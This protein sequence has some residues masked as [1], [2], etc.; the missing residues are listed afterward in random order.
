MSILLKNKN[1][2]GLLYAIDANGK[3]IHAENAKAGVRYKCPVCGCDMHVST[4]QTGKRIFVRYP[5]TE[6]TNSTCITYESKLIRHT[7]DD[8]DPE[9]FI[10][11]LC[12]ASTKKGDQNITEHSNANGSTRGSPDSDEDIKT[13][14][15]TSL[16]QI[17]EEYF[18]INGYA[19]QGQHK[20]S[21]IVLSYKSD[22]EVFLGENH[23]LGA[24]I[25]RCLYFKYHPNKNALLF[26]LFSK[27]NDY[28][29]VICLFFPNERHFKEVRKKF[30]YQKE[31]ENG[32]SKYVKHE[33][34]IAYDKWRFINKK[35]CKN[36][37]GKT[38]CGNCKGMYQAIYKNPKQI[39][40]SKITR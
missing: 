31:Q 1:R 16:K 6:H 24:R 12:R 40:R 9:K 20:I 26:D 17:D 37:C 14:P 34:L 21:D 22:P 8:I 27:A 19:D 5:G 2:A 25:I 13:S 39:Y 11:S 10:L 33:A 3:I 36:L 32:T 15:F 35:D 38:S 18:F 28:S 29:V 4:T 30:V 7:F 23:D